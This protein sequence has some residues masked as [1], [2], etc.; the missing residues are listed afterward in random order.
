M[1]ERDRLSRANAKEDLLDAI[2][3][4][5]GTEPA[6]VRVVINA[7]SHPEVIDETISYFRGIDKKHMCEIYSYPWNC[8]REAEAHFETIRGAS[9]GA[10]LAG[11]Y[12]ELWCKPCRQRATEE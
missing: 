9:L 8:A 2:R 10:G 4:A 5:F 6:N 11:A 12:D 3:T 1:S 7:L